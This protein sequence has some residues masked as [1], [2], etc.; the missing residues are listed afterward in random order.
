MFYDFTKAMKQ[1][2]ILDVR[3]SAEKKET[4][5]ERQLIS[6]LFGDRNFEMKVYRR[7]EALGSSDQ[8]PMSKVNKS[9]AAPPSNAGCSFSDAAH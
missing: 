2:S 9:H 3:D 4:N 7:P 5:T 6:Y 8:L 1:H